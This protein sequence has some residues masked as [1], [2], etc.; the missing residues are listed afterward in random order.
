MKALPER[1][2]VVVCGTRFGRIYLSALGANGSPF[3]LSGILAKGSERSFACARHYGVPLY[4]TIAEIPDDVDIGC[5]VIGTGVIG[6]AGTEIAKGL[7]ER[8]M[9]VL[10]EHPLRHDDLASCLRLARKYGVGYDLNTLYVHL[11]PVRRFIAAARAL[12]AKQPALFLD[13]TCSVLVSYS[14]FDILGRAM[15]AVRPW[16]FDVDREGRADAPRSPYRT[17]TGTFAGVPCT[18]RVQNQMDPSNPDS[19]AHLL[20]RATLMTEGGSLTL[21]N[22]H[23]PVIWC[24]R[25]HM[26]RSAEESITLADAKA[27]YFSYASAAAIGPAEAPNY[28]EILASLWPAGIR[29]ALSLLRRSIERRQDP[30]TQGQYHLT[31]CRLWQDTTSRLGYPELVHGDPKPLP[32]EVLQPS[33]QELEGVTN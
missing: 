23:G 9:H 2:K 17:L 32:A 16:S 8:G 30:L 5:V 28:N 4:S 21:V 22:S 15:G 29:R 18:M 12:L 25:P 3:Q 11:P 26:P 31:L 33:T 27:D 7:L 6:G 13:A 10:Q 20:H 14:M 1:P 24:P 19:H